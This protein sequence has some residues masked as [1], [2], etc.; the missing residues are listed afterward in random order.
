[1]PQTTAF[2]DPEVMPRHVAKLGVALRRILGPTHP[3]HEALVDC[4]ECGCDF[5]NPVSWH[6]Q[7]EAAWWIRIRCGG[8]GFVREV[9]VSNEEA[10]RYDA[11]LNRGTAKIASTLASLDRARM[12]AEADVFKLA[13][14]RDLIGPGDFRV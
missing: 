12:V 1:M 10:E 8:C 2:G 14:E 4:H 5:V 9:E 7:G 3:L 6:A 11:E 13:L